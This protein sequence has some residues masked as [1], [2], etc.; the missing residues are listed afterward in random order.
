MNE[1]GRRLFTI[2][3]HHRIVKK[4]TLDNICF[5]QLFDKLLVLF[6][7]THPKLIFELPK[8]L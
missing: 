8:I 1:V 3:V 2:A 7:V 5:I 4:T 6:F